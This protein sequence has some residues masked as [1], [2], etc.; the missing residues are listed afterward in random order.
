MSEYFAMESYGAYVWSCM[1]L[2][3]IVMIT[4]TLQAWRR[5]RNILDHVRRAIVESERRQ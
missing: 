4:G 3:L 5:Q 1:G 2:T